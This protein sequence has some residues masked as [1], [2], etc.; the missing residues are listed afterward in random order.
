METLTAALSPD[1]IKNTFG[2]SPADY[3]KMAPD[4][5]KATMKEATNRLAFKLVTT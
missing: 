2:F 4:T 3:A 5:K 1:L